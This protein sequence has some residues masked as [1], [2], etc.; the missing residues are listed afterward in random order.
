MKEL[1]LTI[2]IFG[3]NCGRRLIVFNLSVLGVSKALWC[4]ADVMEEV[5]DLARHLE[6]SFQHVNRSAISKSDS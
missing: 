6:T 5:L 1:S 2:G 3:W 4:L